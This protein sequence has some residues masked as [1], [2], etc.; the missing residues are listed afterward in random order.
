MELSALSPDG[1]K[2]IVATGEDFGGYNGPYN[3][4]IIALDPNTLAIISSFQEGPTGQDMDFGTTPVI[5]HDSQGRTLVGANHKNG[6]FY[7][8]DI[9]NISA[10]P[11]WIKATGIYVG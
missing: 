6:A 9:N 7:A 11:V 1:T 8:F 4:A 5:F 10:G 3:R 2:L